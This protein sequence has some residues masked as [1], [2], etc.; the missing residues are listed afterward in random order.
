MEIWQKTILNTILHGASPSCRVDIV[1][2]QYPTLS[3]KQA[4]HDRRSSPGTFSVAVKSADQKCPKQWKK[5]L[6]E[7][8]NK[9]SLLDFL[10]MQWRDQGF[11]G[12]IMGRKIYLTNRD[13]CIII[14][15][16]EDVVVI[17]EVPELYCN[18]EEADT[19][20]YIHDNHIAKQSYEQILIRSIDTNVIVLGCHLQDQ[21]P[22]RLLIKCGTTAY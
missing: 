3:I 22:A 4:E 2:D 14:F 5:F 11:A 8:V 21:I 13:K 15:V 12:V 16:E 9:Q 10:F 20:I 18:H 1:A 17:H 7:G 19:K 6:A